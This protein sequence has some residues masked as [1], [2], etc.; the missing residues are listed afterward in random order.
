[1]STDLRDFFFN[2]R[3]SVQEY[4]TIILEHPD[5]SQTYR[6]VRNRAGGLT[7]VHGGGVFYQYLPMQIRPL[8]SQTDMDQEIEVTLGDLGEIVAA[9]L[10][11]IAEANGFN[12][13]PVCTY[14]TFRSDDTSGR[15]FGPIIMNMDAVSLNRDGAAFKAKATNFNVSTTGE[16][17][18]TGRFPMLGPL[19]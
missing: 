6:L 8:A 17:Y 10:E 7:T 15:M 2:T 1:M 4:E 3:E 12:V 18:D 9:E 13:K 16:I 11:N 5:F 14:A 19:A